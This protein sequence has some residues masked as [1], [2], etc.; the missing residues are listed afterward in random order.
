MKKIKDMGMT[1]LEEP[2]DWSKVT[3]LVVEDGVEARRTPK[4]MLS[5]CQAS[6]VVTIAWL[7]KCLDAGEVLPVVSRV[8]AE[9]KKHRDA[10]K[11][12]T[13]EALERS[14]ALRNTGK[15]ILSDCTVSIFKK[16]AG[17]KAPD[18][19]ELQNMV[20]GAGGVWLGEG[21]PAAAQK[22]YGKHAIMITSDP[23]T[24]SQR[25]ELETSGDGMIPKTTTWLFGTFMSQ[26]LDI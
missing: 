24:R 5:M 4:V 9:V 14:I 21:I 12:I 25:R 23:C 18:L 16:I 20:E 1:I 11:R 26:I 6:Y 10:S 15:R 19:K 22:V 8:G 3:H 2:D 13:A 17:T 7:R